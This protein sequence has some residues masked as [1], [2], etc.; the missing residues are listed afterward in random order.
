MEQRKLIKQGGGGLTV[1][2]P[3]KWVDKKGFREGD[4]VNIT[5]LDNTLLIG[6]PAK[7]KEEVSIKITKENA[8]DLKTIITHAY[9]RG[10]DRIILEGDIPPVLLEVKHISK[11]VLLGFEI[12]E[13][14]SHKLLLENI[15]EPTDEKYD[16][17]L[18]RIFL[19]IK[20]SLDLVAQD[21]KSGKFSNLSEMEE[22]R[23]HLDQL[24][25]F[26]RRLIIKERY[27][28]DS[29]I[30]WELL[31]FLMHIDHAVYYLYEYSSKNSLKKD[32]SITSM[33]E[34]LKS[35]FDLYYNAYYQ[36]NVDC[37]HKINALRRKQYG[38]C[39]YAIEHSSGKKSVAHS[40]IR[41]IFR[42]IQIGSSPI[43]SLI[44]KY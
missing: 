12:T 29:V 15:S 23:N 39:L 17:L 26:C 28:K 8:S 13:K 30:S 25:L 22:M 43:M 42:L 41:E 20:E 10:F 18:R 3:K 37:I 34:E 31:T 36:S 24:V 2:L 1:Y 40:Y 6:S 5:E 44:L 21:F 9:R 4:N 19:I 35:Y 38:K 32:G 7:G 16:I 11:N 14:D 27:S 33:F